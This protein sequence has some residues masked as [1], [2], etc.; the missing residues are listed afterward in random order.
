MSAVLQV[1]DRQLDAEQFIALLTSPQVLPHLL[2]EIVIDGA[3]AS[4]PHTREELEQFCRQFLQQPENRK[5]P[6]KEL[7]RTASRQ[8]KLEKFK[9]ENWG[10]QVE[11]EFLSNKE[12]YDRVLF[13]IIQSEELEI[14]QE[15]YFRLQEEEAA[16]EELAMQYSQG[17]ESHSNGLVGPIELQ[18]LHPK[19]AQMLRISQP[20]QISPPFRV[21]K[22]VAIARL[23]RYIPTKFNTDLRKRLLSQ[24]FEAWVAAKIA[25]ESA[26]L[27]ISRNMELPDAVI[28]LLEDA[29]SEIEEVLEETVPEEAIEVS[30]AVSFDAI[31]NPTEPISDS[32]TATHAKIGKKWRGYMPL[33]MREAALLALIPLALT[34]WSIGAVFG[35]GTQKSPFSTRATEADPPAQAKAET[36][37]APLG[38][39]QKEAFR[40]AVNHAISAA[41]L[42]Q[43]AATPEDWDKVSQNWQQAI[44]LMRVVP[45]NDDYYTVARKKVI[46]YQ[47]YLEY[48]SQQVNNPDGIFRAA[49]NQAISAVNST[50]IARF[51]EEWE[52]AERD[53]RR[54]IELMKKVS[55]DHPKYEIAREKAEEYQIYL[56]YVR[57]NGH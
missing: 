6:R 8:L 36:A 49:V 45:V 30:D 31:A 17:P 50:Q 15:L 41:E 44:A 32:E 11:A 54:A 13:S 12:Q 51:P 20:G 9:E 23:E 28:P 42:T 24:R 19:L 56:T 3:I 29:A 53:W 25:Q 26:T 4:I 34:G 33:R 2:R 43:T 22:W 18:N 16:F 48:A 46:E 52:Q 27:K 40:V 14:I 37:K 39:P 35:F 7:A 10:A 57:G 21:D 5:L 55:E 38:V 1:G 47:S